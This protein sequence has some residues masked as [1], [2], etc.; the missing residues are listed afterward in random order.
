MMTTKPIE[1]K[2]TN[3][4]GNRWT[5]NPLLF[6]KSLLKTKDFHDK[7]SK[8]DSRIN[9]WEVKGKR[10]FISE[11]NGFVKSLVSLPIYIYIY[12]LMIRQLFIRWKRFIILYSYKKSEIDVDTSEM[13]LNECYK[14]FRI[15]CG[16]KEKTITIYLYSKEVEKEVKSRGAGSLV[17]RLLYSESINLSCVLELNTNPSKIL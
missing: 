17:P 2:R 14:L 15:H 5:I 8:H 7:D 4:N 9:I 12:S 1:N 16:S 6:Y 3:L 10:S 13:G 11:G